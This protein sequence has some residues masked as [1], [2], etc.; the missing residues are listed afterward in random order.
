MAVRGSFA[1]QEITNKILETFEGSF[2]YNGGKELR[3]PVMENGDIVQIKITMTAAKVNVNCDESAAV[4]V[5]SST[6]PVTDAN[7]HLTEE[8]KQ[9]VNDLLDKLGL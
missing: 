7:P 5:S 8:E 6:A 9:E 1:K 2:L 4:A 3:I